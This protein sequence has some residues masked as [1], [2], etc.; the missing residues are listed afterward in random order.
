MSV[1]LSLHSCS[2][3]FICRRNCEADKVFFGG[4]GEGR[5]RKGE[6]VSDGINLKLVVTLLTDNLPQERMGGW[7]EQSGSKW[8]RESNGFSQE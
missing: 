5:G 4:K 6:G 8:L 2:I 1:L 7:G 3:F